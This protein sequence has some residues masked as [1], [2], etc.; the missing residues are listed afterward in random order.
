MDCKPFF[1][2]IFEFFNGVEGFEPSIEDSKS[3]A[4]TRLGYTPE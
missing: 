4:L 2:K 3:P 1:L